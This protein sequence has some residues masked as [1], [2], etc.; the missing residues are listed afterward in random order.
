M[1][2]F[3]GLRRFTW[4][5]LALMVTVSRVEAQGVWI[6]W[7]A[8]PSP[9]AVSNTVTFNMVLTNLLGVTRT[10]TLTN[11][12]LAPVQ[13]GTP[14]A[15]QGSTTVSGTNQVIF[16]LGT[17]TNNGTATMVLPVTPL[18]AGFLTNMVVLAT[19]GVFYGILISDPP[20]AQVTNPVVVADLAVAVTGP[21][22][23][24]YT[25]DSMVYG[26][27]VTN[28]G[29]GTAVSVMLTNLLPSV[30]VYKDVSPALTRLGSSNIVIFNL[31]TLASG[32]YAHLHLSVQPTNSGTLTFSSVVSTN[33]LLDTNSA[34]N[35]A[36]IGV[37]VYNYFT[38]TLVAFTNSIQ[39]FNP[40]NGLL[41]Q[42][43]VV[44]NTGPESVPAAR[45]I[46]SGTTNFLSNAVGTND[47]NP[48][49]VYGG[50][51]DPGQ[52][53]DLL[54]QYLVP[55]HQTF[56]GPQLTALAVV[57]PNLLPPANLSTNIQ[58]LGISRLSPGSMLIAFPSVSN[59]TYTV[60]YN[61][62]LL[63]TNWLAAQ[64][65]RKATANYTQWIDYG[66]PGT[67][68]HPTNVPVR[69]YRVFLNP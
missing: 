35:S 11:T 33:D 64:P 48:F 62:N 32:D 57:L 68:D 42:L 10:F 14:T 25:N 30:V 44:S 20:V 49:V 58:V 15:S 66:P 3:S 51:L 40:Q 46:V 31:G 23:A 29:P 54:L 45:V 2:I 8:T 52:S 12:L 39:K 37:P 53:V 28:L 61:T 6:S 1:T 55:S 27:N 4:L 36:S 18:R 26:V 63:T 43:I 56:P 34:N 38:N 9:V 67:V 50:S 65:A 16:S 13:I 19:N 47:G 7:T 59:R 5:A 17:I 69:F 22:T 21:A 60:E 41:E 24:V